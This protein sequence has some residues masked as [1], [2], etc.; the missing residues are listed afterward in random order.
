MLLLLPRDILPPPTKS[1]VDKI[2]SMRL[3][4]RFWI[5]Q[6]ERF[7]FFGHGLLI[8]S[9][10]FCAISYSRLVS[11]FDTFISPWLFLLCLT[12]TIGIFF[13]LRIYDEHK[14]AED[15]KKYRTELPVP[16]G[17]ISLRE[18][19]RIGISTFAILLLLNAIFEPLVL[20]PLTLVFIWMWLMGKEF[21]VR[22]WLLKRQFWYVVSH[23]LIIPFVDIFASSFDWYLNGRSAPSGLLFFFALSFINGLVLEVGRKLKSPDQEKEGVKTYSVLLGGRKGATLWICCLFV[24][25]LIGMTSCWYANFPLVCYALLIFGFLISTFFGLRYIFLMSTRS[26]KTLEVVSGLWSIL[27]YLTVG[28]VPLM[29]I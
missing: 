19:R 18:L 22:K 27:L 1:W 17:L 23:M 16:R 10:S 3:A 6:K 24:T 29:T 5:Y 11:G 7:P 28:A 4:R 8:G 9:F 12:N 15:D 25:F 14:D 21:F 20:L 2:K 26:A 13:I